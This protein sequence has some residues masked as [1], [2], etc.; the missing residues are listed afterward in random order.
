MPED[1]QLT[2]ADG[3]GAGVHVPLTLNTTVR[4]C[5]PDDVPV[6]RNDF[7]TVVEMLRDTG[8]GDD[9]VDV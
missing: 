4:D 1:V 3:T 6:C 2:L 9:D 5:V 8:A 7:D